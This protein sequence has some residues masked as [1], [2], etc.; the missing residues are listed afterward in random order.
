MPRVRGKRYPYT[1]AGKKAATKARRAPMRRKKKRKKNAY[2][3][4]SSRYRCWFLTAVSLLV[5]WLGP[6]TSGI[7]SSG[8]LM[9][10]VV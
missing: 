4:R 3:N 5:C 7:N 9:R 6:S 1:K 8:T 10:S 2:C